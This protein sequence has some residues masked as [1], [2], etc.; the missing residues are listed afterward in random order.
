EKWYPGETI[1]VAIGGGMITSTPAQLLSMISTVALRG[2]KPQIHLMKEIRR[3]GN[4]LREFLPVFENVNIPEEIFE[5]VIEGLY[6]VVN[7]EGTGRSAKVEGLDICGKTGTQLI[8]SLENPDY[9]E[10]VK[11]RKFTP[12]SWF[13]SFAPKN[14]PRYASVIFVE[15]GGDAGRIAAPIAGKI[16]R[17]LF[18]SE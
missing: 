18:E 1:S 6:K 17:R 9:K 13:V 5:T 10:L 3:D 16:Y 7:E 2:K 14:N 11:K 15:N 4:K 8:L 12:H